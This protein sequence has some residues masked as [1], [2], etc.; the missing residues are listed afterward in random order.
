L[1]ARISLLAQCAF[2][3]PWSRTFPQKRC[4]GFTNS[5]GA[6]SQAC[7]LAMTV[8][9]HIT[10]AFP[11][12]ALPAAE[13]L[14]DL[15]RRHGLITW[16]SPFREGE[17]QIRIEGDSDALHQFSIVTGLGMRRPSVRLYSPVERN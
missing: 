3:A 2:D 1:P 7:F 11:E 8:E 12:T 15:A 17:W 16:T 13:K 5:Q 4:T 9:A 14:S 10:C 6:G